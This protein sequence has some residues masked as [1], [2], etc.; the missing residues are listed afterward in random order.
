[1]FA[2]WFIT[3]LTSTTIFGLLQYWME[4][5]ESFPPFGY[6]FTGA[7]PAITA[8]EGLVLITETDTATGGIVNTPEK[9]V[10]FMKGTRWFYTDSVLGTGAFTADTRVRLYY[11]SV[12]EGYTVVA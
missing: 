4:L 12:N 1:M 9:V 7:T 8:N 2:E 6:A 11:R 10:G 3:T 5:P